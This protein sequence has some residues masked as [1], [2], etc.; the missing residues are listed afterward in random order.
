MT[1]LNEI[2]DDRLDSFNKNLEE[3]MEWTEK[4]SKPIE[5]WLNESQQN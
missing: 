3:S 4:N 1:A 2:S 5:D